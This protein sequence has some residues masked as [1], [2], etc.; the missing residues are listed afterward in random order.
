[1]KVKR[2]KKPGATNK[3]GYIIIMLCSGIDKE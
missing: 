1:M 3:Y 2:E